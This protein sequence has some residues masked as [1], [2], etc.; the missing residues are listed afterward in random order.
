MKMSHRAAG[1]GFQLKAVAFAILASSGVAAHAFVFDVETPGLKARWDNTIRANLGWRVNERNPAIAN[2]PVY[3][4][5]D[6]KFGKGDLITKRLDLLS[7]FDLSY[8]KTYGARVSAS[9]WYDD[10]YSDTSVVGNPAYAALG[11]SYYN[12]QYSSYTK[13]WQR[14]PSGEFLDAFVWTNVN[15]GSVPLSIKVG[16]FSTFWGNSLFFA[17]GIAR[18]Q[19]PIDGRKS[20]T[21]P[22]AEVKELF[23]PLTQINVA[24]QLDPAVSLTAQYYLD[25][26][27]TRAADGGT[28]FASSDFAITGPDRTALGNLNVSRAGRLGPEKKSG[29]FGVNM[30]FSPEY[31]DGQTLGVYYR[32]Y[33]EKTPWFFTVPGQPQFREVYARKSE[34]LGL[35]F[36]GKIGPV[37]VGAEL[38]YHKHVGLTS[39]SFAPVTEGARGNTWHALINGVYGLTPSPLWV[40]GTLVGEL[41]YTR[42]DKVTSNEALLATRKGEAACVNVATRAPGGAKDGCLTSDAW[43]MGATF[44][45][46]YPQLFPGVNIDVPMSVN[47]GIKGNSAS[48]LG[49]SEGVVT[50]SIGVL[51]TINAVHFVQMTFA[52]SYAPLRA[53]TTPLGRVAAGGNGSYGTNDRGRVTVMY[54]TAF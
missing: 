15:A 1:R 13:R 21:S 17:G 51:A 14:G 53:V 16:R 28:Y 4:E 38:G 8:Q 10:A 49:V 36:D 26:A 30:K 18:G 6:Y 32:K 5:S 9:A 22:G 2:S 7:E 43:G 27:P 50:Y 47:Y 41:T 52:D 37:S 31:F 48:A 42:L 40:T 44:T 34:L 25:W 54:R 19:Q 11:T 35:G 33:D 39:K 46:Q 20:A 45:P 12:A 24:A 29:N 3:D 23:L